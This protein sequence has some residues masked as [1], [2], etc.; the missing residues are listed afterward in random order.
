M[1]VNLMTYSRDLEDMII[2]SYPERL[3]E[4]Q[5]EIKDDSNNPSAPKLFCFYHLELDS[6]KRVLEYSQDAYE[7]KDSE[8]GKIIFPFPNDSPNPHLLISKN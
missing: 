5:I 2:S 1:K 4:Y 7:I 3:F 6:L 8:T